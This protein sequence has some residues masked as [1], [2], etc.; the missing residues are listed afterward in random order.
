MLTPEFLKYWPLPDNLHNYAPFIN[1]Y[2]S[3]NNDLVLMQTEETLRTLT[4]QSRSLW[5]KFFDGSCASRVFAAILKHTSSDPY[6][7]YQLRTAVAGVIFEQLAFLY[8]TERLTTGRILL[9]PTQ[10]FSL[11]KLW[12]PDHT[13]VEYYGI[14]DGLYGIT[15]P[16]G[17]ELR[18]AKKSWLITKIC[19]YKAGIQVKR[20][21]TQLTRYRHKSDLFS[22]KLEYGSS[23]SE[24]LGLILTQVVPDLPIMP[25]TFNPKVT[26]L[27]VTPT[28][29]VQ[30]WP[31]SFPVPF[32]RK[33]FGGVVNAIWAD[34]LQ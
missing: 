22:D 19:E 28:D 21:R 13:V 29:L 12:Y 25:V 26:T 33:S 32:T 17:F 11:Y 14:R 6:Q 2:Q 31:Q 10:T 4:P 20:T 5:E 1:H 27:L 30:S 34:C 23:G 16:D 18:Q 7:R 24:Q 3:R 15:V 8:L 9:S